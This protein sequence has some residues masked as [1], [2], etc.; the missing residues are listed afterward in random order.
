MK[1]ERGA[2]WAKLKKLYDPQNIYD[3]NLEN[4][5]LS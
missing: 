3:N 5:L 2:E 1:Q 4:F